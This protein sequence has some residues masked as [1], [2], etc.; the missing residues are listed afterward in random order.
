MII[1]S[2]LGSSMPKFCW[3]KSG[4]INKNSTSRHTKAFSYS[5]RIMEE[6]RVNKTTIRRMRYTAK[7]VGFLWIT[8]RRSR[9]GLGTFRFCFMVA[10]LSLRAV[11]PLDYTI[12]PPKS[13]EPGDFPLLFWPLTPVSVLGVEKISP[14]WKRT[15]FEK[16][17]HMPHRGKY[18]CKV[19]NIKNTENKKR[20]NWHL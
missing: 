20:A 19:G 6:T 18:F 14:P 3:I 9:G 16:G 1:S 13:K 8:A 4:S 17:I 5:P 7:T 15:S 2:V 12:I 10:F 11:F